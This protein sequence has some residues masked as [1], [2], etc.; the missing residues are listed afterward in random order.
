MDHDPYIKLQIG[1]STTKRSK[2]VVALKTT[3]DYYGWTEAFPVWAPQ[4]GFTVGDR[5]YHQHP[6]KRGGNRLCG[7]N[8]HR[9]CRARTTAGYPRGMTNAFRLSSSCATVDI[10]ELAHFTKGDWCWIEGLHGERISRERWEAIYQGK[11]S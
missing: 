10:A 6:G 2:W 5:Y 4:G 11:S 3:A 1:L 9:I 8:R 7:G